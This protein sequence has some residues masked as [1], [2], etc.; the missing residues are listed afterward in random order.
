MRALETGQ[1]AAAAA[2][3]IG[4]LRN[5]HGP[6][7]VHSPHRPT[8]RQGAH[9]RRVYSARRWGIASSVFAAAIVVVLVV[10]LTSGTGTNPR[11]H[12][13]GAVAS[14]TAAPANGLIAA[15]MNRFL[16]VEHA[17]DRTLSPKRPRSTRALR[18]RR[19]HPR[20][21]PGRSSTWLAGSSSPSGSTSSTSGRSEAVDIAQ[22]AGPSSSSPS[23][24]STPTGS[25][26]PQPHTSP[27][28]NSGSSSSSPSKAALRSLVTGAGTCACQ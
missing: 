5:A 24:S 9:H 11:G 18:P 22:R 8:A 6:R 4:S 7:P 14:G 10:Q 1:H 23:S 20:E 21:T 13:I 19:P 15:A 27:S 28:S 25:G 2:S 16:A 17:A 12:S 26:Q 3:D